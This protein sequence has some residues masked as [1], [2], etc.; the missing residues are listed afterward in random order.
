MAIEE[1]GRL[2]DWN[3]FLSLEDD[4][5]QLAR[6]IEPTEQNFQTYSIEL[7]R[8]LLAS[9]AEVDV[10]AKQLCIKLDD[11]NAK[12]I[13]AYRK[14]ITATYPRISECLVT[15]PRFGLTLRPWDNWKQNEKPL[16]W[17]GYTNIKHQRHT[18]FP[19][20][21]L[22][23]VLNAVSGLFVLLIFLHRE[24]AKEGKLAPDPRIFEIGPPIT[25]DSLM[26]GD[27]TRTYYLPD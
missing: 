10:T 11:R 3:L 2:I 20:A 4:I 6:Y 22:K 5:A 16:W 1:A 15:L 25:T 21:N 12:S 23:N 26:W 13:D 27:G 9:C 17:S 18:H 19:D 14:T 8:L 24:K 7:A